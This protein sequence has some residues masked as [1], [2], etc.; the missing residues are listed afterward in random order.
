MGNEHCVKLVKNV[1][2]KCSIFR[3]WLQGGIVL[4]FMWEIAVT[5]ILWA[6]GIVGI[7]FGVLSFSK[8]LKKLEDKVYKDER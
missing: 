2:Q 1:R 8:R 3:A 7:V 5:Q 6:A 4:H